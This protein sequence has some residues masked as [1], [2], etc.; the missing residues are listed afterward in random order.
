MFLL[1]VATLAFLVAY[2]TVVP[3]PWRRG[4][5][6]AVGLAALAAYFPLAV[7]ALALLTVA[8]HLALGPAGTRPGHPRALAVIAVLVA[9]LLLRGSPVLPPAAAVGFSYAAFRLIHVAIERARG[10]IAVEGLFALVEYALFPPAFLSG[11]IERYGEFTR[12]LDVAALD[13][14]GA[15]FGAR[16]I[17]SGLAKKV[18]LVGALLSA[19]ESGF[20][21]AAAGAAGAW[22]ALLCYSLYVYL[23]F[24]AYTD[25]ALGVARLFGYRLSENFRWPYLAEDIGEFWRRWHVTLSFWLRDYLY[26]PASMKLAEAAALRRRPLLVAASSAVVTMLGC[27]LWH[28]TTPS[29]AAWGL[30]HGLLLAGHQVFRQSVV[31]RL[32]AKRRKALLASPAYRAASAALTFLAVTI[33]WTFFRFPLREALRFLARLA[34]LG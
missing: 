17:L 3:A 1:G 23:D 34:G 33:L 6:T 4:A 14:D 27:G 26:L 15:F 7:G 19:A 8:V 32:P 28:G 22:R 9:L 5:F 11:P 12:A 16:R 24:S 2:W 30:G 31:G 29:F 25:L 18:F 13:L 10:K 20:A 21:D